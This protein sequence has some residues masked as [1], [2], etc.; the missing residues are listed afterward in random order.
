MRIKNALVCALVLLMASSAVFAAGGF[1][2]GFS[3]G[4]AVDRMKATS[5]I[6]SDAHSATNWLT[7]Y[8]SEV[9]Y[10]GTWFADNGFGAGF[11]LGFV[12]PHVIREYG[13]SY[14][15]DTTMFG[16]AFKPY[17]TARYRHDLTE[18]LA[19]EAGLGVYL[20]AGSRQ[21]QNV[22]YKTLE[23]G[24]VADAAVRWNPTGSF[25]IKGGLKVSTPFYSGIKAGEHKLTQYG[26]ELTP[27]IGFYT[28]IN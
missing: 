8:S 21:Y 7:S 17:I 28:S 15:P 9:S 27:Y 19:W 24:A 13:I 14:D 3:Y 22:T 18:R 20:K 16:F 5:D 2:F 11:G 10:D 1:D 23:T 26:F 6:N 12:I 25:I 4:G